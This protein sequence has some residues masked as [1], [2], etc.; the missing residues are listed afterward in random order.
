MAKRVDP[1][2]VDFTRRHADR[3]FQAEWL[4]G[5]PWLLESGVDFD[6]K[7]ET[8][9]TRLYAEAAHAGLSGRAKVLDSGDIVFQAYQPTE[10]EKARKAA[11]NEKR[12]ATRASNKAAQA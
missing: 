6:S 10:D 5:E 2:A 1:S 3:W 12:A 9:R 7:P 4:D 8:I 11:A